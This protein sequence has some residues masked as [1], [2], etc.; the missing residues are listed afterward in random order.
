MHREENNKHTFKELSNAIRILSADAVEKA[1]SGHPGMPL[2]MADVATILFHDFLRFNPNNPKWFNRDRFILSAGH[3]SMLLYSLLYLTGY[4]G[5]DLDSLKSFRQLGSITAGHPEYRAHEAIEVTTGPLGQGIGN[6]VGMAIAEKKY[7]D[8][9]GAEVCGHKIYCIAGD[10][11]LMEGVGYESM[12]LAGH[13]QL[14]N[15]I[16]LFDD[17]NITI[18]GST[19]LAISENHEQKF[20]AMGWHVLKIDGHDYDEIHHALA[21]ANKSDKPSIIMCK[22]KI[23][24]GANKKQGSSAAHG[25]PLGEDEI[26]ALRKNLNWSEEP[27]SVPDGILQYWRNIYKSRYASE[28]KTPNIELPDFAQ[29]LHKLKSDALEFN[30]PEATRASSGKMIEELSKSNLFISG[31]AD[32]SGS[33]LTK[34]KS[35]SVITKDDFSGN[36]IHYGIREAAM[37]AIMNGLTLEG[38]RCAGGTFLVFSDYMRPAIRLAALMR[39]PVCYVMTHDSIGVGEDGPT[40]QPIEHLASLR[41]MPGLN[42]MRPADLVESLECWQVAMD[43]DNSKPSL[44]S[45]TR[46]KLPQIRNDDSLN[47]NL[48]ARGAYVI[49]EA[50]GEKKAT[51]FATGSE[52]SLALEVKEMLGD[53]IRVVS[54]PSF[55]LFDLQ[56]KEYKNKILNGSELKVAIEAASSFGW[57]KFI[58]DDGLFFGMDSFGESAPAT[59]LYNHFGL[60]K[61][62]I[63]AIL[64]ERI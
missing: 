53:N 60:T 19:D 6:A 57:Q 25:A 38:L 23:G 7:K 18:D 9:Y 27:F 64:K 54:V 52:V 4:E 3:G 55:E 40:H 2:G 11:C 10:G 35:H 22:T 44:L 31:S 48:C 41:A 61:E 15:L 46:Q 62:K 14:D 17:N 28:A 21:E 59:D 43:K 12:S 20:Q 36:Y 42:V 32:L 34:P 49:S 29:E 1:Q 37:G 63:S 13:L 50:L 33:N 30:S 56:S 51:I 39:I 8:N 47:K 45:L 24:Y 16:I 58:G 5:F 26:I